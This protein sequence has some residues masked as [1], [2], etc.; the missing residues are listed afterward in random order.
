[1]PHRTKP[2]ET[3][4]HRPG[5]SPM[6]RAALILLLALL[7]LQA[8]RADEPKPRFAQRW[9]YAPF[10]LL[11]DKNVDELIGLMKRAQKSGYNGVLLADYKFNI[12]GKMPERYFKNV[13][14]VKKA[15]DELGLEI[16]PAIFPIGY[17]DG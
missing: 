7:P 8:L 13:E 14:R 15:A 5:G 16:V 3:R 9:F 1:S 2:I 11:V 12:L 17:S 10:N 4:S 6:R